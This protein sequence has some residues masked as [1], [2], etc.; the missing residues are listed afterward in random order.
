MRR[1]LCL[2]DQLPDGYD[3]CDCEQHCDTDAYDSH[4]LYDAEDEHEIVHLCS[5][6]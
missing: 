4:G 3:H 6:A 5:I 2:R 1:I